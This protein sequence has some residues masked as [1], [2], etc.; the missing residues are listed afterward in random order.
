MSTVD[1]HQVIPNLFSVVEQQQGEKGDQ[2]PKYR[3]ENGEPEWE[4]PP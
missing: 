2:N 3:A 4:V 1:S